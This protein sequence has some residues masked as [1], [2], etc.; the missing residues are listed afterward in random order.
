MKFSATILITLLAVLIQISFACTNFGDSCINGYSWC[1]EEGK[2]S[3]IT[4]ASDAGQYLPYDYKY[5]NYK[6][7]ETGDD[8]RCSDP[9]QGYTF[10]LAILAVALITLVVYLYVILTNESAKQ[11]RVTKRVVAKDHT[12]AAVLVYLTEQK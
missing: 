12:D 1:C 6:C 10:W 7:C 4:C 5:E 3:G 2:R 9:A 8:K 11:R